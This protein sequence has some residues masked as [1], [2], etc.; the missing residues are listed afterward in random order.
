M[1]FYVESLYNKLMNQL[2]FSTQM[3]LFVIRFFSAGFMLFFHGVPKLQKYSFLLDKFPDPL[4]VGS[5]VSIT[6]VIFAE[7]LCSVLVLLGVATRLTVIPLII[8]MVVAVFI[9][10]AGDPFAKKELGLAFL[11]CYLALFFGGPGAFCVPIK[12]FFAKRSWA[13][14][15]FG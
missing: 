1:A 12:R 11:C 7:C 14:W 13:N 6:L 8:T 4:G 9:V 5:A 15:V 3:A 2:L 10:H